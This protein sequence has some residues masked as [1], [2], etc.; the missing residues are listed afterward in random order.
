MAIDFDGGAVEQNLFIAS[1]EEVTPE[2]GFVADG[3]VGFFATA[4]PGEGLGGW[5][6]KAFFAESHFA[7]LNDQPEGGV[8]DG[9]AEEAEEAAVEWGGLAVEDGDGKAEEDADDRATDGDFVGDDEVFKVDKSGDDEEGRHH[10]IGEG[11][12]EGVIWGSVSSGGGYFE[13][14]GEKEQGGE[15]FDSEVAEGDTGVTIGTFSSKKQPAEEGNILVKRNGVF[16]TWTKGTLGLIDRK[17]AGHSVN[18]NIE[19]GTDGGTEDERKGGEEII[20]E[21]RHGEGIIGGAGVWVMEWGPWLIHRG[22]R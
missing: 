16:A 22:I 13:P 20:V 5:I 9:G 10:C 1:V 12:E 3:E 7:E 21:R 11:E 17:F 15:E 6:G 4:D 14:N 18:A 8:A 19:K 2:H